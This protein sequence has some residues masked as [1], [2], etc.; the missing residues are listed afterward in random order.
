MDTWSGQPSFPEQ[1][2]RENRHEPAVSILLVAFPGITELPNEVCPEDAEQD[3]R[4][5]DAQNVAAGIHSFGAS[6]LFWNCCRTGFQPVSS[7][8]AGCL[9]YFSFRTTTR[10][11]RYIPKLPP[12]QG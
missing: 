7:E 10:R 4:Q 6:A 5:P 2:Q 9:S 12:S 8:Q 3:D 11:F 1:G